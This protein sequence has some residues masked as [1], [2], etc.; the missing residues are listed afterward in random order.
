MMVIKEDYLKWLTSPLIKNLV[1]VML[2]LRLQINLLPN[3]IH[4]F[5]DSVP[6]FILHS[7]C[8]DMKNFEQSIQFGRRSERNSSKLKNLIVK[9]LHFSVKKHLFCNSVSTLYITII[10][11]T[12]YVLL[13][14]F[15]S[16]P[17]SIYG[18][19]LRSKRLLQQFKRT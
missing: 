19:Y 3:Q 12:N 11:V 9:L 2:L 14:T 17:V 10:E 6:A 16:Q 5:K 8:Y 18:F 1:E 15:V 4:A 13:A 7:C